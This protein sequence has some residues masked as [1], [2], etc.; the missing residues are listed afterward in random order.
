VSPVRLSCAQELKRRVVASAN[1]N[2]DFMVDEF[3]GAKMSEAREKSSR[4]I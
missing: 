1:A 3:M 4:R 2:F